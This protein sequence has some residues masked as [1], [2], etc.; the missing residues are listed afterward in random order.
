MSQPAICSRAL[1]LL[2]LTWGVA[3]GEGPTSWPVAFDLVDGFSAADAVTQTSRLDLGTSAAR[4]HLLSG[5]SE[6]QWLQSRRVKYVRGMGTESILRFVVLE[7]QNLSL[8]LHGQLMD[9]SAESAVAVEVLVNGNP[10]SVWDVRMPTIRGYRARVP[11]GSLRPGVNELKLRYSWQDPE[12][13][14]GWKSDNPGFHVAWR[15]L[16]IDPFQESEIPPPVVVGDGDSLLIPYGTR[17]EYYL[18]LPA[19]SVLT[20][21]RV[22]HVGEAGGKLLLILEED[23]TTPTEI[24]IPAAE[25]SPIEVSVSG[26]ETRIVRLSLAAQNP[27]AKP[28]ARSGV[29]MVNPVIRSPEKKVIRPVDRSSTRQ[30][31]NILLYVV[32]TLRAD[33]L[34]VYGYSKPVSPELDRFATDA[35]VFDN[36]VAQSSWTRAAMASIFTG[37]WPAKH[38]ANGR[39]DKLDPEAT[40][41]AELLQEAGYATVATVRNWNVFPV[42][43]FRQG[44]ENFQPVPKGKAGRVTALMESWLDT[45]ADGRPFFLYAH[46]VDPHG[47][48]RPPEQ[49]RDRFF[50][51]GQEVLDLDRHPGFK[52]T[53][54]LSRQEQEKVVRHLLSLYDGEIASNDQAFGELITVL[55]DRGLLDQT[56]IIYVSDHGE[57]FLEHG[58][59]EHGRNL[60]AENLNVPLIIRFPDRGRGER[61]AAVV[62]HIDLLPTILEYVGLPIP[63]W[64]EGR[65]VLP[66]VSEEEEP[67]ASRLAFSFLHLDGLPN[68]SLVDGDWKLIE[69]VSDDGVVIWTA[70]FNRRRDPGDGRNLVQEFPIRVRFM[71]MLLGAKVAEGSLLTTEEAVL[72]QRTEEAL[73]A[74]GYLQ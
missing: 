21:E 33:H 23:A 71:E 69:R 14:E 7:P 35:T 42:F 73:R 61:V 15:E 25:S 64:V 10:I 3:C 40:T 55:E 19:N 32:D 41:L 74:L 58:T 26:A 46:T 30:R 54:E 45:E 22:Q 52:A 67:P 44:F 53:G 62:Q 50:E 38:S 31:P 51:P 34:G 47:P 60:F 43:G 36:C 17:V 37:L 20:A 9:A 48:Y 63:D 57:E 56:L 68:R 28:S 12:T 39:K 1:L 72:D 59:W 4:R 66:L 8:R 24:T 27:A 16:T 2:A 6:D 11:E 18:R 70:L 13:V 29:M 5:W 65:S 49:F